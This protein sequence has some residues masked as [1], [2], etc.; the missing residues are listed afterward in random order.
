MTCP[1]CGSGTRIINSRG[2][3]ES[4]RRRRKCRECGYRFSTIEMEV[5]LQQNLEKV[6]EA[7]R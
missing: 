6:K 3:E 4:V 1:V 7:K 2:D 5:D